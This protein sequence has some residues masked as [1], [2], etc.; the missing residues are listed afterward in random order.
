[1]AP[2]GTVVARRTTR[3]GAFAP[4]GGVEVGE[5]PDLR[6]AAAGVVARAFDGAA[7]TR[8]RGDALAVTA[9]G[10]AA[11]SRAVAGFFEIAR[12]GAAAAFVPELILAPLGSAPVVPTAER[13]ALAASSP[14]ELRF[15]LTSTRCFLSHA[16]ASATGIFSSFASWPTLILAI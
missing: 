7:P 8:A 9:L 4:L 6:V 13:R 14:M 10:F 15:V 3:D 12:A 2:A 16:I 1:L 5:T 11:G